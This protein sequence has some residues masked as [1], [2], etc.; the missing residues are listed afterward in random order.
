[1]SKREGFKIFWHFAHTGD[2]CT[3]MRNADSQFELVYSFEKYVALCLVPKSPREKRTEE[4]M[5]FPVPFFKIAMFY[6]WRQFQ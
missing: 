2:I 1:M 6:N 4:N 3:V 5:R